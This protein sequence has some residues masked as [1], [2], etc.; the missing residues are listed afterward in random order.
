MRVFEW[1]NSFV[2]VGS[3]KTR[4]CLGLIELSSKDQVPLKN[5]IGSGFDA[6]RPNR[7]GA[8]FFGTHPADNRLFNTQILETLYLFWTYG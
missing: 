2:S 6:V 4:A 1:L 3:K 8:L 7:F 5:I